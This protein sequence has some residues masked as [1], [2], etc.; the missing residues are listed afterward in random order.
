MKT[1]VLY[2]KEFSEIGGAERLVLDLAKALEADVVV[3]YADESV[4]GLYDREHAVEI[5]SLGRRLPIE[6]WRQIS[7]MRIFRRLTLSYDFIVAMDDMA[8]RYLTYHDLPH[9]YY[10]LT[11]RRALYD[12]NYR[13][14]QGL[15]AGK[16][17]L[18]RP[19]L[20]MFRESDR[21]FVRNHVKNLACI[22][23][24][25]RNRV[26]KTYLRDDATVLYPPVHCNRY[27]SLTH[28]GY[29]LSVN[30]VDKW[31]RI[32]LQIE[33]FRNMP[34]TRLKVVGSVYP[35]YENVVDQAPDNIEF[36]GNRTEEELRD[37]YS[38]CTGFITTAIDEDFGITPVEAMASGKPVVATMEGG[39][40]ETVVD[41][42]TGHLVPP[43][44]GA[45]CRAIRVVSTNPE[46]YR[47][48]CQARAAL[49]DY[50]IF[51]SKARDLV[52]SV[53]EGRSMREINC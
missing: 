23:H 10:L 14:L 26:H 24:T 16:R 31:K 36:L 39:Y 35:G 33:T 50:E 1:A 12:L 47:A 41:S 17:F 44:V 7:S 5:V 15:P 8:V 18:Y 11:P 28:E 34:E 32:E 2:G 9:I 22:S 48:A 38:R 51:R 27:H 43:E 29:W 52:R 46:Q 53:F 25:V 42:A 3:P 21:R 37:L 49:F 30:R 45:L 40:Q 20:A 6:P 4:V 13:F 19:A